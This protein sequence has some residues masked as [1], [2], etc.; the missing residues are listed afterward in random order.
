M[1]AD[2]SKTFGQTQMAI[3]GLTVE[4][5]VATPLVTGLGGNLADV[6]NIQKG[7]AESLNTNVIT[8]GETVGDLYAA[9]QAVGIDSGQ[10]GDMVKGF[11]DAGI[12]TGNIKEN[13]QLSVDI[14]RKVGVNTSAVFSLVRD[15]L[16]NINKYGFENG[17]AGLAKMSAQAASL[18]INMNE[19]FGFAERV[20]NPE[21]AIDLVA[22]LQVLG[23][24]I[25]MLSRLSEKECGV[26]DY[27]LMNEIV[28]RMSEEFASTDS[29]NDADFFNRKN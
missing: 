5:A 20:F 1:S 10:I 7:I 18:R 16:S 27:E 24:A 15:N 14:A 13:I 6:Q 2:I 12:Q 17:V 9:G 28:S 8:L 21:G 26:K 25:V 23:G 29:F 19:I 11:Q 4:L 22:N 3:K